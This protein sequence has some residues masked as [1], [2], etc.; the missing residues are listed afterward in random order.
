MLTNQ[1]VIP[2][3]SAPAALKG[4]SELD[5][6][7]SLNFTVG[8]YGSIGDFDI[9][10]DYFDIDLDDRLSLSSDFA[11]T[12]ADQATLTG[13]GIDASDISEFRF[14]TN[15]FD[16]NTSGLDVVVSTETEWLSGVTNGAWHTTVRQRR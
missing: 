4:G 11:L 1:G 5:P 12:A 7:E 10:V 9:T 2:S 3:T 6:E 16:T 13:Q 8:V 15:Q 14:F